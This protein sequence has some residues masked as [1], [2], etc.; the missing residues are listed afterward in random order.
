MLRFCRR[1][2]SVGED[3]Y[4]HPETELK[5]S[6]KLSI[7]RSEDHNGVTKKEDLKGAIRNKLYVLNS[8]WSV[9]EHA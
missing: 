5:E 1:T 9:A 3:R 8:P 2:K 6:S 4:K 7:D